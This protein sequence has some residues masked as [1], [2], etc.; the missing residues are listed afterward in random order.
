M[1]FLYPIGP[2]HTEMQLTIQVEFLMTLKIN[3]KVNDYFFLTH[4]HI[5][6]EY[7]LIKKTFQ[8]STFPLLAS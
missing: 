3:W 1:H 4:K 5:G 7:I 2:S 6:T 8:S